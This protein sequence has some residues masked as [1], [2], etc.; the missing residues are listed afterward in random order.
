[1]LIK[2]DIIDVSLIRQGVM[3]TVEEAQG[4]GEFACRESELVIKLTDLM[5]EMV[6]Q[7][8]ASCTIKYIV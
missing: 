6:A 8:G 3:A 2:L 5:R 7:D 4:K 1:M